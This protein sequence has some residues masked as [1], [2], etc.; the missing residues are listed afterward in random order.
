MKD[1][2]SKVNSI[3]L[4][5]VLLL[6]FG[7]GIFALFHYLI[8]CKSVSGNDWIN[9]V[10][11][12]I[13]SVIAGLIAIITFY[14]TIKN[15]NKNQKEAHNLQTSLKVEDNL[16]RKMESERSVLAVT[17]N[18]LEN[19][20]FS[21]SNMSKQNDNYIDMKNDYLQL[22][23]EVISSINNIKFNSEIFDDRSLCEN[24]D[25]CEIKTYGSLVKS[26]ADIQK[27]MLAIDK[28]CRIVLGHLEAALNTAAQSKHLLDEKSN[29]QQI[30]I[31]NEALMSIKKAQIVHSAEN[32]TQQEQP[33]Y[34]EILSI[35][36]N[37]EENN[38]RISEID[39]S[40]GN[41]LK[42]I[43]E[44]SNLARDKAAQIDS[45][46][47]TRLYILIRKYFTIYSMYIRETVY[48]VQKNGKP[49]NSSCAKLDFKKNHT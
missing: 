13:G 1:K 21:V 46:N 25:M 10:G 20:L 40:V 45:N 34:H 27:E 7:V 2:L 9:F 39:I 42:T 48:V 38:K 11:G 18:Q 44:Q 17:Y 49:S 41:N 6:F 29:L 19:F 33:Y 16:N 12:I 31:N 24:C 36:Q 23:K 14:F 28:E 32:L 26:A 15:N 37:I 43:S 22:Y 8:E 5:I 47:K 4:T 3:L 30:N 35:S